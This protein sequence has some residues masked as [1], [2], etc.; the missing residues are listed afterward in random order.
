MGNAG[1]GVELNIGSS[2]CTIQSNQ[3]HSN[4]GGIGLQA[5]IANCRIKRNVALA[6]AGPDM[7]DGNAS[8]ST[9][10][11]SGNI[12]GTSDVAGGGP[13]PCLQ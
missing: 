4:G 12:F 6:N 7:S 3:T 13:D 5:G 2:D 11:W 10:T 1:F 9:N 8:C